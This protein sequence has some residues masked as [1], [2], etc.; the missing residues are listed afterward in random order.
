M[1]DN[2]ARIKNLPT[3][4][5]NVTQSLKDKYIASG[6]DIVD[7]SM[8]NPDQPTPIEIV[9]ELNRNIQ[10]TSAHRYRESHG[11]VKLR[12]SMS[13]WLLDRFDLNIDPENEVIVTLGSKEGI[14]H[15]SM[16]TINDG[17]CVFI[18][19]PCYPIHKYAFVLAGAEIKSLTGLSSQELLDDLK[20]QLTHVVPK[21]LVLNFPTNPTTVCVDLDYFA[22]IV[23]LAKKY[24]F[25]IIHDFAYADLVFSTSG[26]P[27]ILQVPG[28]KDVAVET[29]S[30]SKS[31][32]MPGWRIGFMYGNKKLVQALKRI[33]SYYDYGTY[34][35]IQYSAAYALDNYKNFIPNI[36]KQYSDR[37]DYLCNGLNSIG[38]NVVKP[39]AT[40]FIW[41]RIPDRFKAL[42]SEQFTEV[43]LRDANVSV[44]PGSA[45]GELGNS[46]VRLSLIQEK[47]R[48]DIALNNI[49]QLLTK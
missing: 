27:S 28:A 38:W 20:R 34:G 11:I 30:M 29:Y 19:D 49:K 37:C 41:A 7:F 16:A 18:P 35:P 47:D 25:W 39:D 36:L 13:N 32:N 45:F 48:M 46:Y 4:V 9:N 8:G 17:E 14:S 24:K 43:L 21:M 3:Y 10:K 5:F 40:M 15:L 6:A 33:K 2:F 22:E 1:I 12:Q 23:A 31:F 42:N 44:T 26:H